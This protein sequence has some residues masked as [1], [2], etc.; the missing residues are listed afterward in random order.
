MADQ[1]TH[2]SLEAD[3]KDVKRMS[4]DAVSETTPDPEDSIYTVDKHLERKLMRKFDL[5]ILPLVAMMYLFKYAP[6]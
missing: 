1:P 6:G 5:H 3:E 4:S 2:P